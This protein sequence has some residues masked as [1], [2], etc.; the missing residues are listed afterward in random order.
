MT[1]GES[2]VDGVH[3]ARL[4]FLLRCALRKMEDLM[5]CRI[6]AR[7]VW[8]RVSAISGR[9]DIV[10][11]EVGKLWATPAAA[12]SQEH[13]HAELGITLYESRE[14]LGCAVRTT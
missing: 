2:A 10:L 12:S 14:T 13:M 1:E 6:R 5:G 9:R 7:R 3:T 11:D 8:V 4:H